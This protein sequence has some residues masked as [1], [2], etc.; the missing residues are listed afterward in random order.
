MLDFNTP[1]VA[2][3]PNPS[4]GDDAYPQRPPHQQSNNNNWATPQPFA[5][6]SQNH[7]NYRVDPAACYPP[8]P[9]QHY[10]NSGSRTTP[11]A[12]HLNMTS[13]RL[14]Q[15]TP[16]AHDSTHDH[17]NPCP[18]SK[19]H[20]THHN[21]E[22]STQMAGRMGGGGMPALIV[23]R[24]SS[25]Q[26]IGPSSSSGRPSIGLNNGLQTLRISSSASMEREGR[27]SIG[28]M[29]FSS[30]C[31]NNNSSSTNGTASHHLQ[32]NSLASSPQCAYPHASATSPHYD[33]RHGSLSFGRNFDMM[34]H[35]ECSQAE[36]E[37]S[38]FV[39][40]RIL[41]EFRE[42]RE[43]GH[44][45]F[46]HVLLCE[47]MNSGDYVAIKISNPL[48]AREL[49]RARRER[50]IMNAL[51][52][53]PHI[54]HLYNSWEEG[55]H[56]QMHLQMQ[57]CSG[58]NLA[59][60]AARRRGGESP[61]RWKEC[62]VL[63]FMGQMAIAL[64]A[65]H[66]INVVH[67]DFKPENVLID[68]CN[69][70][71]L[72]DFGC[73]LTL[74]DHGRPRDPSSALLASQNPQQQQQQ[75]PGGFMTQMMNS[76]D[77]G[78]SQATSCDEGD[79]RYIAIDMMNEKEH[80]KAGDMFSFGMSLYELMSGYAVPL[81]GDVYSYLR[82]RTELTELTDAGYSAPL[83]NLVLRMLSSAPLSRPTAREV[84]E[85]PCLRYMDPTFS[86]QQCTSR[87]LATHLAA[88][89]STPELFQ[90]YQTCFEVS[91]YLMS[92][93]LKDYHNAYPA[94][95]KRLWR[96]PSV[97]VGASVVSDSTPLRTGGVR[98][99]Q[100]G[101]YGAAESVHSTAF[102]TPV[103]KRLGD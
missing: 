13:G 65:I 91:H 93:V 49:N 21:S 20:R 1:N 99:S 8:P 26:S 42:L 77:V 87:E 16:Q 100:G 29:S 79:K 64:D 75:R 55:R 44:G 27:P 54:V 51:R 98:M 7:G 48:H 90:Y 57:Y 12:H 31:N 50:D 25:R 10:H 17:F 74:D 97:S 58:G 92:V 71:V 46:G 28:A 53:S 81:Q 59:T 96:G 24:G 76:H 9:S 43:L 88:G 2:T 23:G 73:G 101:M 36:T 89:T 102:R 68:G 67:V 35:N 52:G 40:K 37:C 61:L 38:T 19:R 83:V 18:A 72:S 94:S 78:L 47:E 95:V 85:S 30:A 84:L 41:T 5:A 70:Y 34:D 82:T 32:T 3:P 6:K 69:N 103:T 14:G 15:A 66:S 45:H 22:D 86:L 33:D 80:Y 62:E 56:P 11:H 60:V 63:S 4:L 39:A